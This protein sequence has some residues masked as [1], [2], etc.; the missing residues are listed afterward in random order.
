ML[1]NATEYHCLVA[2][3]SCSNTSA[4]SH[5]GGEI[6]VE[7]AVLLQTHGTQTDGMQTDGMQTSDMLQ[8]NDTLDQLDMA[9]LAEKD[10]S[11]GSDTETMLF[12][13][14]EALKARGAFWL[15]ATP[16]SRY[17]VPCSPLLQACLRCLRVSEGGADGG[18]L[19][20]HATGTQKQAVVQTEFRGKGTKV[21]LRSVEVTR[22]V[23][24]VR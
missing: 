14:P 3:S 21:F 8:I 7:S 17:Y 2:C 12:L 15:S 24:A 11:T 16:E 4:L 1:R 6:C 18:E 9:V 23:C 22:P 10:L 20:C 5:A 13:V 19:C